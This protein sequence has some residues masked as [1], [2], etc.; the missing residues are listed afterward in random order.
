MILD[1]F[2]IYDQQKLRN[3]SVFE[4]YQQWGMNIR[5]LLLGLGRFPSEQNLDQTTKLKMC[6]LLE[7]FNGFTSKTI[8]P[9]SFLIQL[10]NGIRTGCPLT[11]DVLSKI[12]PG[13]GYKNF[14]RWM[15]DLAISSKVHFIIKAI[16]DLGQ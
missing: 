10:N 9:L 4:Y 15:E 13:G 7:I 1:R 16:A 14:K 8:Q 5:S 11:M 3:F 6:I 12:I 2:N